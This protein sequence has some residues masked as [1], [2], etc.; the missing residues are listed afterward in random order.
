[1]KINAVITAKRLK[2]PENNYYNISALISAI[3]IGV[4]IISGCIVYLL[5]G[6]I[7]KG[8]LWNFFIRFTIEFTGKTKVEILTGLLLSNVPYLVLMYLFGTNLRGTYLAFALSFFKSFGLG[9]IST[10]IYCAYSLK[11]IEYCLL[12]FFPGKVIQIFSMLLLTENCHNMSLNLSNV[13]KEKNDSH[14]DLMRYELRNIF[15]SALF[16][17]SCIVDFIM[18]IC[19]S[20]LFEFV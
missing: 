1:M 11:G 13:V 19:F 6:E 5:F 18:I 9:L 8:E 4:G 17:L 10:Y 7:I 20:T 15:I 12:I 3:P 2:T 14:I 16:T